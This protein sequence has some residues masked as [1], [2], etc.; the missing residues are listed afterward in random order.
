LLVFDYVFDE[1][2]G[3]TTVT[4]RL[5]LTLFNPG[6]PGTRTFV[7]TDNYQGGP[8]PLGDGALAGEVF[9]EFWTG[10]RLDLSRVIGDDGLYLA[11]TLQRS[12]VG[13]R[14]TYAG[15]V[16]TVYRNSIAG[17]EAI[18]TFVATRAP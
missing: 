2:P 16:G 15:Y 1:F 6:A 9:S 13:G 12:Q 3:V 8:H 4:G 14:C 18:G 17:G 5:S 7:P 10:L 11:G